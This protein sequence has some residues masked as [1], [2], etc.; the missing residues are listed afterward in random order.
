VILSDMKRKG[1]EQNRHL[2]SI[3]LMQIGN[4]ALGILADWGEI[5]L[6]SFLKDGPIKDIPIFGTAL[7]VIQGG[8]ALRDFFFIRKLYEFVQS[9][10]AIEPNK[11]QE[12]REKLE[13]D[14]DFAERT[15]THLAVILDRLDELEKAAFLAKIFGA[16]I[17]GIIDQQQ[18]KRLALALDRTLLADIIALKKFMR[19]EC[20]LNRETFYGL[21][22]AGLASAYHSITRPLEPDD[23]HGQIDEMHFIVSPTAVRLIDVVFR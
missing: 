20:S 2:I 8:K 3:N 19:D 22:G 21:E 9:A 12:F 7:K 1:N 23:V 11:K 4:Q 13:K 6:D 10:P 18:T 15:A 14:P 16:Y 5:A 17:E